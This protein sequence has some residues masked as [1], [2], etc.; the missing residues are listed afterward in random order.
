[1][2]E[3]EAGIFD[4]PGFGVVLELTDGEVEEAL[5]PLGRGVEGMDGG[6]EAGVAD[7]AL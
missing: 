7:P 5:A 3:G 2:D 4:E 1:L 6:A